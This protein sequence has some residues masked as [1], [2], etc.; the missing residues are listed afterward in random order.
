MTGSDF[1]VDAERLRTM[2]AKL[3]ESV[4]EL[5]A[6]GEEHPPLPE[7]S[8]SSERVGYTLSEITR[9]VGA[10]I[11]GVEEQLH[12]GCPEQHGRGCQRHHEIEQTAGPREGEPPLKLLGVDPR[13]S[14]QRVPAEPPLATGVVD[15]LH[16]ATS[17]SG[18][19]SAALGTA[20]TGESI[21]LGGGGRPLGQL[22][23]GPARPVEIRLLRWAAV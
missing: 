7:A 13:F 3:S 17:S 2:S 6:A 1:E 23:D 5:H 16:R 22:R 9:T 21:A 18:A 20:S 12:D 4:T 11:A 19:A 8:T 14:R 15:E 10:I